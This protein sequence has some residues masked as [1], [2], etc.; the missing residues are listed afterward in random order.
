MYDLLQRTPQTAT[1]STL[2][3]GLKVLAD[4]QQ[5]TPLKLLFEQHEASGQATHLALTALGTA[6]REENN[7]MAVTFTCFINA[8][9]SPFKL[10]FRPFAREISSF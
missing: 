9:I 2:A 3:L 4:A 5:F 7:H 1:T 10:N 6:V 8:F